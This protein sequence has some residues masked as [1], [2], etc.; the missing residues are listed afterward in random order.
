MLTGKGFEKF[1]KL[2]E[3]FISAVQII[4]YENLL[5]HHKLIDQSNEGVYF[6][7]IKQQQLFNNKNLNYG[8]DN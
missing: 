5:I 6:W 3:Y 8:T 4:I 7:F 1:L 2:E